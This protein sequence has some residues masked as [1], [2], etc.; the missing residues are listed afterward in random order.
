V[1]VHSAANRIPADVQAAVRAAL[2]DQFSWDKVDFGQIIH[3]SG[4]Y[5]VVQAVPGV[6]AAHI[7]MLD[8]VISHGLQTSIV[9]G[10][11]QLPELDDGDLYVVDWQ[12]ET[13]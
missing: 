11:T 10:D 6:V 13:A 4:V 3:E 7:E 1:G 9:I 12:P 5:R 8:T 2:S